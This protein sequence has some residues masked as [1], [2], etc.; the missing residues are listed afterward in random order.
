MAPLLGLGRGLPS[1]PV[2]VTVWGKDITCTMSSGLDGILRSS[3]G[4]LHSVVPRC[5]QPTLGFD[6]SAVR[7][8][9]VSVAGA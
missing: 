1:A 7:L 4:G 9:R 3:S 2:D 6:S 8:Y 5:C